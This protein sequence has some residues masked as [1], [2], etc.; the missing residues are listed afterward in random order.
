MKP[1]H[2]DL[3]ELAQQTIEEAEFKAGYSILDRRL[4]NTLIADISALL[5]KF[6]EVE[7][8]HG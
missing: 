7:R 8:K 1:S 3:R 5:S 6:R 2:N 4:R